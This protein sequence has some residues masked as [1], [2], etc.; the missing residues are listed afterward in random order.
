MRNV[1]VK[2]RFIALIVM[3]KVRSSFARFGI[4]A[5]MALPLAMRGPA[6]H[7]ERCEIPFP[8]EASWRAHDHPL[9]LAPLGHLEHHWG[10][11]GT[12]LRSDA[13]RLHI[14]RRFG[15]QQPVPHQGP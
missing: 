15:A 3:R 12:G 1:V 6:I 14:A 7:F 13:G 10:F 11:Q 4:D 5:A 8:D 2:T 9:R